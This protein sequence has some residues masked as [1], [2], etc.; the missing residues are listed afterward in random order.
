ML[1]LKSYLFKLA[2]PVSYAIFFLSSVNLLAAE[3]T[4]IAK[5]GHGGGHHGGGHHSG[6]HSG[7]H[8]GNHHGNHHHD[9]HRGNWDDHH[10]Y[11]NHGWNG[12]NGNPGFYSDPANYYQVTTPE[13]ITVPNTEVVPVQTPTNYKYT[14]PPVGK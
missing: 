7:H 10:G 9:H 8:H 6:H 12:E 4:E 1:K 11:W 14:Q 5:G 3:D 13:V 2:V